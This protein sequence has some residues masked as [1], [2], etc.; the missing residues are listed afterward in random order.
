MLQSAVGSIYDIQIDAAEASSRHADSQKP[1]VFPDKDLLFTGDFKRSG[2]DLVLNGQD[3]TAIILNYFTGER[4]PGLTTPEGASLTGDT[5]E[6]LTADEQPVRYAQ[7][8]Q[9]ADLAGSRPP[10]GRVEK[11]SGSVTVLRNGVPVELRLGDTV[12]KGDV[13][14]TGSNAT[15]A[16]RFNDG[17]VFLLSA[18]A[19][20]VLNDMVYAAGSTS[21]S[22]LITLVQGV[23]GFV[24]GQIAKTGDMKVD[25]PVA[26]MAIRGTAVQAEISALSGVTKVSVLT[27]PDG[28][29]GHVVLLDRN[30][31]SRVLTS[32]SDPRVA[33]LLTPVAAAEPQITQI[34]KTADDLRGDNDFVK[35]LFQVFTPQPQRRGSS[36]TDHELIIPANF[37]MSIDPPDQTPL[38]IRFIMPERSEIR[39][40]ITPITPSL[41]EPLR[42]RAVEDG[43]LA[44]LAAVTDFGTSSSGAAEPLVILPASLPSGVRYIESSH[45]FYLDPSHPAYQHLGQGETETITVNYTL[46]IDGARVPTSASW[47]IS[48]RN[49][50][51]VA[52]DDS[53]PN[54]A[55]TGQT[56]LNVRGNDH[57]MDGDTLRVTGWTSPLE[58][59]VHFDTS[60][61]LV[62]DPGDDFEALSAGQTATITFNYTVSDAKGGTGNANA[63]LTVTGSGTFSAAQKTASASGTIEFNDQAVAL[64]MAAQSATTTPTTDLDIAISLGPVVQPQMNVLY[65]VD[66]S[67]STSEK[68]DGARVGDLN[69]DGH[70]NTILDAEIA[71]LIALTQRIRD[72][73]F[74]PYD[75]SITVIPFN[76]AADPTSGSG[77]HELPTAAA[78]FNLGGAGDGTIANYL[79]SLDAGGETNFA[80]ALRAANVKLQDLDQ[81]NETNILYFLSDGSG[82]GSTEGE[83]ARLNNEFGAQIA[84][85][86]IGAEADLS[87]LDAIDNTDGASRLVSPH[88]IETAVLGVPLKRGDIADVDVFVNGR[89][90][91][92]VGREDL[93]ATSQGWSL[94]LSIG[95]LNRIV[96]GQNNVAAVVTFTSGEVLRTELTIE[97]ALP[98]STDFVL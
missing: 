96:G 98:R 33:T 93:I 12:V 56:I 25:T 86:G 83:L 27:E 30:N 69:N 80:E 24:A 67:G 62:F 9:A 92:E 7:A 35:N 20:I 10:I 65:L 51:P 54:V 41:P 8:A 76:G 81:G 13:V 63:T 77:S 88:Q 39:D 34:T 66:V 85:I 18:D 48:G 90:I 78:T 1:I 40:Q 60:G 47:T 43:P 97:G 75:V 14:Q 64:T 42:G 79:K 44:R 73:G 21:N 16:I 87:R 17:T 26:T 2:S 94:D 61:N 38:N 31:H 70:S 3:A 74:S 28:S 23:I 57:D 71:G 15:V 84:A 22:T 45:S 68:F 59:T 82:Q 29:V 50:A 53:L 72:L 89:E 95:G 55:E 46:L 58:G 49:D 11:V 19:R 36:D 6:A 52:A 32:V 4:R 37:Q 91:V 5:V